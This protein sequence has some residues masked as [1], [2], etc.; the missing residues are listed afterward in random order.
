VSLARKKKTPK[1]ELAAVYAAASQA[2]YPRP[3]PYCPDTLA[4][5]WRQITPGAATWQL[6]A[7]GTFKSDDARLSDYTGWATHRTMDH[8]LIGSA[9]RVSHKNGDMHS[10]VIF[11]HTPNELEVE[12]IAGAR[13]KVRYSLTRG[14]K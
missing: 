4:G 6:A 3:K 14:Q 9:I 8:D 13:E 7:T 5:A 12:H 10:M 11:K 2:G 1:L